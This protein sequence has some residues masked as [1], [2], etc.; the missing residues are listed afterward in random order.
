MCRAWRRLIVVS[1]VHCDRALFKTA[2]ICVVA[3]GS[4]TLSG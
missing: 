2:G 3:T 1:Y 4:E